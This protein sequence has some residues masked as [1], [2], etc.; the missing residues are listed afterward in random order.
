MHAASTLLVLP[1]V[2]GNQETGLIRW[3]LRSRPLVWL[4]LISYGIYLW[5]V[6]LFKAAEDWWNSSFFP[7]NPIAQVVVIIS[8]TFLAATASYLVVERPTRKWA[9]GLTRRKLAPVPAAVRGTSP[10]TE[11]PASATRPDPTD[12]GEPEP[13]DEVLPLVIYGAIAILLPVIGLVL[14]SVPPFG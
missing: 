4:G 9:Q 13:D 7:D 5:H 11:V 14:P 3:A 8:L 12:V 1:A 10:A 6:P 2:F